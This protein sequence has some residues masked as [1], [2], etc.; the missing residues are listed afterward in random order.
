MN[1]LMKQKARRNF[2][3]GP[4]KLFYSLEASRIH[5][6]GP[7]DNVICE[8][9]TYPRQ[10]A[11]NYNANLIEQSPEMYYLIEEIASQI[12]PEHFGQSIHSR[13]KAIIEKV[14]KNS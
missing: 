13:I 12:S 10:R 2:T 8:I 14:N 6:K 4:W 11:P 9:H 3:P 7:S 1:P 5:I